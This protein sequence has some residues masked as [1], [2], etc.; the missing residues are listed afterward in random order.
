[1]I[2]LI[3]NEQPKNVAFAKV[4]NIEILTKCNALRV[5]IGDSL[6]LEFAIQV[7]TGGC[8]EGLGAF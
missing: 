3:S 7:Q 1:M 5:Y 2:G 4:M 6:F 8:S